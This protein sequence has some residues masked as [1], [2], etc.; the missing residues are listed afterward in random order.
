MKLSGYLLTSSTTINYNKIINRIHELG[1][2]MY[3]YYNCN[4]KYVI[5]FKD[6]YKNIDQGKYIYIECEDNN[7]IENEMNILGFGFQGLLTDEEKIKEIENFG[8]YRAYIISVN[9]EIDDSIISYEDF[10]I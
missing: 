7:K 3:D 2:R 1:K 8:K 5:T 6:D 9:T 4:P 10:T